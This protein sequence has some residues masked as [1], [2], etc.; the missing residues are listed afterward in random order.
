MQFH[1]TFEAYDS[2]IGHD[3]PALRKLA[4][5]GIQRIMGT[6][7]VVSSG[8]FQG[9]RGGFMIINA[10]SG[11]ELFGIIGDMVDGFNITVTPTVSFDVL[12]DY[13]TKNPFSWG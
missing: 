2:I 1:V 4:G 11:E 7:K 5:A 9:K 10:E 12:G 8:L 3:V 13:F 6:G